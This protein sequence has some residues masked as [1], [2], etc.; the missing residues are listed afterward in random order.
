M[1]LLKL[2]SSLLLCIALFGCMSDTESRPES[3]VMDA[4]GDDDDPNVRKYI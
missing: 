4:A 2:S 1:K 3:V